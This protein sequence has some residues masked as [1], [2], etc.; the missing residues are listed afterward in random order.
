MEIYYTIQ[1][2]SLLPTSACAPS[3]SLPEYAPVALL[4]AEWAPASR[5]HQVQIQAELVAAL[6]GTNGSAGT[7]GTNGTAFGGGNGMSDLAE[8]RAKVSASGVPPRGRPV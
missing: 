7:Q 8:K 1:R 5:V 3:I 6:V 4:A 2:P